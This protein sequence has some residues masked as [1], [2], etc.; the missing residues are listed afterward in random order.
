M[1]LIFAVTSRDADCHLQDELFHTGEECIDRVAEADT[2]RFHAAISFD[3]YP[4]ETWLVI[5]RPRLNL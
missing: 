4:S 5:A 1:E 2:R 3:R